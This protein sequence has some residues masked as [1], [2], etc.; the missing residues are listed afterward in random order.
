M[1]RFKHIN[2]LL[3]FILHKRS[4]TF[5]RNNRSTKHQTNKMTKRSFKTASQ[6]KH[7]QNIKTFVVS[8]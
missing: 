6:N 5:T 8:K 4:F 7:I 2:F 3:L 1:I